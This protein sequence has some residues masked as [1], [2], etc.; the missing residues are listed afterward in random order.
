MERKIRVLL[1]KPGLDGHDRGAKR[2]ARAL[3]DS[4]M[5]VIY[6]PFGT[7]ERIVQASI[8]EN[9]DFIGLSFLSGA[10]ITLVP[11]IM[12]L[13][14]KQG[15]VDIK[16]IVGGIIPKRDIP[17]LESFGVS[18]VFPQDVRMKSI[19]DFIVGEVKALPNDS[20]NKKSGY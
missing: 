19:V 14:N 8:Q 13:L 6:I 17:I 18:K 16:I 1:A 2:V 3:R 12:E 4:G 9:A 11:K 20:A 15:A 5:E 7:P 10:H